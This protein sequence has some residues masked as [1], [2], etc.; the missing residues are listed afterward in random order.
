MI[1][2]IIGYIGSLIEE[3][4]RRYRKRFKWPDRSLP[5]GVGRRTTEKMALAIA[6]GTLYEFRADRTYVHFV[7]DADR[8]QLQA[9]VKEY[10]RGERDRLGEMYFGY[11]FFEASEEELA[12]VVVESAIRLF[13]EI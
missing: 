11:S 4:Y 8:K 7:T 2:V 6:F 10:L 5:V 13:K 1:G 3:Q 9:T 12:H